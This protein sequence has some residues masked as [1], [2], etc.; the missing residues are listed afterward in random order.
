MPSVI[1]GTSYLAWGS[2]PDKTV[3]YDLD[4]VILEYPSLSPSNRYQLFITYY[5]VDDTSGIGGNHQSLTDGSGVEIHPSV[6]IPSAS[7]EVYS[8][9]VPASS[10]GDGDLSLHFRRDNGYRAVV[11][12][13]LLVE[14]DDITDTD[15]PSSSVTSPTSGS[16]IN[17]TTGV[18][19]G[20]ASDAGSGVSYVEV[21]IGSGNATTWY[22]VTSLTETG[23]WSFRWSLP[24][25]GTFTVRSRARDLAGNMETPGSGITVTVLNSAPAPVSMLS[26]HDTEGDSG[27][28]ISLSWNL[29]ADDGSGRNTVV[30][31][32]IL[33][34]ETGGDDFAEV[35]SV[36]AGTAEFV[37]NTAVDGVSYYYILRTVDSAGNYSDTDIY[38]PVISINNDIPDSD[39]PEDISSLSGV[40][41]NGF[42]YLTWVR[43]A[44]TAHDLV[45]QLIEVSS[46][47]SNWDSPVSLGKE[48]SSYKVTGLT[49][50]SPY[51]F[52]IRCLDSSGNLSPG[53]VAGPFTPDATAVITVSGT[54]SSDT[55]WAGGVYYVSGNLTVNTGVTLT[56]EPGV[57]VKFAPHVYMN[58]RGCLKASGTSD[59]PVVFTA[60]SD[61]TY[62]GDSNGDGPSEGTPG[63]WRNLYFYSASPESRLEHC[64]IKYAGYSNY[65]AI[66]LYYGSS[67]TVSDTEITDCSTHGLYTY[68]SD[69]VIEGCRISGNG[70]SG[71]YLR[72]SSPSIQGNELNNNGQHGIYCENTRAVISNNIITGNASYG[73]YFG[74]VSD[75][76]EIKD[77]TITGN[78]QSVR[79]PFSA[80]PGS[81]SGNVLTPNTIDQIEFYGNT[82]NRSLTLPA[83]PVYYQVSGT[84]TV[85]TGALLTLEPGI[86]WKFG[87]YAALDVSGAL[88]AAGTDSDRIIF[89]SWR[90]DSH[91]GDTNDDGPTSGEP[92]DWNGIRFYD[93]VID[94]L[95]M[96]DNCVVRYSGV[97]LNSVAI[98][99]NST[100]ITGGSGHGI[101]ISGS[102][103][104]QITNCTVSGHVQDGIYLH[105]NVQGSPV[106]RNNTIT[107]NTNGIY[108]D[109]NNNIAPVIDGN[110]ITANREWGIYFTSSPAAPVITGNTITGNLRPAMLP[111]TAVPGSSDGN[112]L[113]PNGIN[114]LGIRGNAR[115]DDFGLEVLGSG[116]EELNTYWILGTITA[117]G[118][119]SVDPGVVLKFDS[120]A[121]INVNGSLSALGTADRP[122]VFTS[123]RD[124]MYGG[125]TN[126]DGY[127]TV[128]LSGDWG[129]IAF[130]SS[131]DASNCVLSHAV[132][133]YGGSWNSGMI[134]V[135]NTTISVSDSIISNSS[136]NGLRTWGGDGTTLGGVTVF[137]NRD[138]GLHFQYGTATVEG[139]RIF[140]NRGDGIEVYSATLNVTGSEFFANNG[141]GIRSNG[142][143]TATDNYWGASDG[144]S[145]SG[146]G[147]GDEVTDGVTFEPFRTDGT[148]YSYF[149]AGG[150]GH[151][152]YGIGTPAVSGTPSVEWGTDAP[153]S[154]LYSL[155]NELTA[156]YIGLSPSASYRILVTYIEKD[157]GGSSQGILDG[158]GNELQP[159][160]VLPSSTPQTWDFTI[161]SGSIGEGGDLKLRLYRTAGLRTVVSELLLVKEDNIDN[162]PP[163]ISLNQPAS[164]AVIPCC[165]VIVSGTVSDSGILPMVEVGVQSEDGNISWY[166]ATSVDLSGSW[167][168][169]WMPGASGMFNLYAR[170]VDMAGNR[171]VTGPV[172]VK[173]DANAPAPA[174]GLVVQAV[175]G[176]SNTLKLFWNRSADDG[177]GADD[178]ARYEIYRSQD[179]FGTFTLVGMLAAGA[180]SYTDSTV[181][182]GVNYFYYVKTV[183]SAGK[184]SV[185]DICGPAHSPGEAD[186]NPPEDVT[187]LE[188]SVTQLGGSDISVLLRWQPSMDSEGDL[189]D[190]YLY[191]S[192]D[193][194]HFG[195]NA[196]DYDNGE[197]LSLGRSTT[198]KQIA[199]L[200]AGTIYSFKITVVDEVP[201][202][203]PGVEISVTPS[204]SEQEVVS[205]SGSLD[206][207]LSLAPGVY[208][209]NSDL[210]V[211]SGITL[212]FAPGSI[213]KFAQGRGMTVY[214]TLVAAG[215]DGNPVV[216]TS[217]TDDEWGGDTNGDGPSV[218]TPGYWK[219][220]YFENSDSSV[221][222]DSVIRFGGSSGY[223]VYLNRSNI[224][225]EDCLAEHS[226]SS[227]ILTYNSDT[228]I[229]GCTIRDN[230]SNGLNIQ[231]GSPLITGNLITGNENGIYSR[232]AT[233]VIDDN[234]ITANN[235][236]G[237]YHYDTRNAPVMS[238]NTITGNN[239]CLRIPASA[240]PDNTN[241]L[242]PNTMKYME[243][244]GNSLSSDTDVPV[245][246]EGTADEMRTYV[247]S[248]IIT[249][250]LYTF[251]NVRPGVIFK[252]GPSAGLS[253]QGVILASGS[254]D[255]HIV[256]TSLKDDS[257]GGDTNGDGS[258]TMPAP[259]DWRNVLISGAFLDN[260]SSLQRVDILYA[261]LS[262]NPALNFD[263]T[264]ANVSDC[265]VALSGS[266]GIRIYDS[267]VDVTG[268]RIWGNRGDGIRVEYRS[269][270]VLSFNF[271]STNQAAGIG[272][273]GF[274]E[275]DI[276]NNRFLLNREFGV[277]NT[278]GT[279]VDAAACWWG[280]VDGSGPH[281]DTDNPTGT[282]DAVGGSI[283]FDPY[284][285]ESP[286]DFAYRNFSE[287]A[288][289]AVGTMSEP[290]LAQGELYDG[291]DS[292]TLRPDRT[293]AWD[294]NRVTVSFS[295]L[296]TSK[297][298]RIR[299]SYF[300]GDPGTTIQSLEDGYGNVIHEPLTMPS[301]VPIQYEFPVP[302]ASYA[303]GSLELNFIHENP[304]SSIR[305]AVPEVLLIEEVAELTPPRLQD[306]EFNDVDGSGSI[307]VGDEYYFH[308]SEE[309]DRSAMSDNSTDANIHLAP[310]SAIYGTLNRIRWSGDGSTVIVTVTDGFTITGTEAVTPT[311]LADLYGNGAIGTQ[312]LVTEDTVA[313][314]LLSLEWLDNDNSVVLSQGDQF[315]FVFSEAMNTSVIRDMT[316]D[317]N[318]HLRPEG[319]MRYG[320]VNHI[321]WS[322]DGR[323]LTVT[324]TEGYTILG[325]ELVT[326][327]SFVTD[328]AGNRVI[329]SIRLTG[330]DSVAPRITSVAFDDCDGSGD[331]SAG[332]RY[333]FT[334]SEEMRISSLSDNTVEANENLSPG[335]RLYGEINRISWNEAKNVCAVTI[336]QGFTITGGETVTPSS[337]LTDIAG[338]PVANTVVLPVTDTVA[339]E[340]VSVQP[341]YFSP[342][343]EVDDY[344][345][346]IRFNSS[347]DTGIEPVIQMAGTGTVQPSVTGSGTWITT[348][349]AND[350]YITPAIALHS[351]M[352]GNITVAVSEASDPAGNVMDVTPAVYSF[353]LDATP[354]EM[355]EAA[356]I[357]QGC[358]SAV[359]SWSGYVAPPDLAAFAIYRED[360]PF[361]SLE[362]LSPFAW[363]DKTGDSYEFTALG[364]EHSYYYAVA[365]VD[366]TGNHVNAVNPG[367]IRLPRPVPPPVNIT[368]MPGSDPDMA[369]ISWPS[370]DTSELCGLS[371][372]RLYYQ[373]DDFSSVEGMTPV[374]VLAPDEFQAV[375]KGLDRNRTYHF[376]VAAFNDADGMNPA[377]TTTTWSD[378]YQGD[379]DLDLVLGG[380]ESH[381]VEIYNTMRIISGGRITIVPGTTLFFAPG[382]GI[383]V[384]GGTLTVS[385]TALDPVIMT[386]VN[387]RDGGHPMPGDWDGVRLLQ[388]S[389]AS[390]LEHLFIKYGSGLVVDNSRPHVQ[391]L[392][393]LNNQGAGLHVVNDARLS[394]TAL[395]AA[396][397][398]TGLLLEDTSRLDVNQ[399]VI[400]FN[401]MNA[402]ATGLYSLDATDNWWGDTDNATVASG[403]SGKVDF[404]PFMGSEPLLTPAI[405]IEGNKTLTGSRDIV[406][407]TAC[408]TA[409]EMRISEDSTFSDAYF[410]SFAPS[411]PFTLSAGGGE[412]TVFAQY[413]SATGDISDPVSITINYVTEGPVIQTF[414]LNEGEEINRPV[415]VTASVTS[416][417]PFSTLRFLVDDLLV[418]ETARTSLECRWDVTTLENRIYRAR[419]VATDK[420]GNFAVTE[421][422]ILVNVEPPPA[423]VITY[424]STDISVSSGPVSIRG[425]AEPFV[426]VRLVRN[427]FVQASVVAS[428]DGSFEFQEVTLD[429]GVNRFV[430]Q[431]VDHVGISPSSNAIEV[432]LDSGPPS[433]VNLDDPEIVS[434]QG[435][436]L[437]WSY[438]AEGERPVRFNVYRSLSMFDDISR[439]VLVAEDI[440]DLSFIDSTAPDGTLYYAITGF[441]SAGNMS[442]LSNVESVDFDNTKPV[443]S[444]SY[445]KT[446]PFGVED[447]EI[448]L[449]ASEPLADLP[450][451]TITPE[452]SAYTH[453]IALTQ[454][455]ETTYRGSYSI[456]ATFPPGTARLRV[457]GTDLAGNTFS[458]I[459]QGTSF[460][461]DNRPPEAVLTID[462]EPPVQVLEER[463]V[464]IAL[465]LDEP[466]AAGTMPILQ[467]SPP[468]GPDITV[469]LSGEGTSW[470][471]ALVLEPSMGSGI[472]RF[473]LQ[474]EDEIGNHGGSFS[475]GE[476]LEIYNSEY[477]TPPSAPVS[478]HANTGKAGAVHVSWSSVELADSYNIYRS[479]GNCD[480]TP[481]T[482]VAQDLTA[483]SFEDTPPADGIYCYAVTA[484]RRGAESAL[485]GRVAMLSDRTPPEQ[486]ENLTVEPGDSGISIMWQGP[487][488]G[489]APARYAVYRNGDLIRTV[490]GATYSITDNPSVGG[491]YNYVVASS[492]SYGNENASAPVTFDL[493]VG[494]V[495]DLV[496]SVMQGGV[497]VLSWHSSDPGVTGYNVYRGDRK[498]ND[499]PLANPTYTDEFYTASGVVEY[500][501]TAVNASGD[502]SPA[503]VARVFPVRLGVVANPDEN[504][505]TGALVTGFI[506][507]YR[508]TVE[509]SDPAN[510]LMI[511][512]IGYE[513]TVGK[514]IIYT[515][516]QVVDQEIEASGSLEVIRNIPCGDSLAEHLLSITL[517]DVT[518]T[519]VETVYRADFVFGDVVPSAPSV[520]LSMGSIPVAGGYANVQTCFTN[521]GYADIA[522]LAS[523][524]NGNE[525]G[526]ISVAVEN[527]DGLE[528][529]RGWYHGI[530]QGA[531]TLPDGTVWM[532][533]ASGESFCVDVPVLVPENLEE[534]T[535]LRFV[536]GIDRMFARWGA[537]VEQ[538]SPGL[539]GVITSRITQT[540]Y[541]AVAR[542]QQDFYADNDV[543]VISGQAINR[544]TGDPEPDVPLKIGFSVRGFQWYVDV[545]SDANG[546]FSYDYTPPPGL[547]GHFTVW[548]AH[549]DVFDI[550]RQD[551]FDVF[552][553]YCKPGALDIRMSKGDSLAFSIDL[554]NPGDR[555]LTGLSLVVHGYTVDED[556][557]RTEEPSFGGRADFED[558]SLVIEPGGHATL[559]MAVNAT[560]D[561]P[562]NGLVDFVIHTAEGATAVLP[563]TLTLL[564]AIP[565][566]NVTEPAAGYVDISVDRGDVQTHTITVTNNGLR[567]LQDV[568]LVPPSELSWVQTNLTPDDA[569]RI[570]LGDIPVGA[571][572][573][574][575]VVFAPPEDVEAGYH[576]D[577]IILKGSNY[578]Q[579]FRINLYAMVTSSKVGSVLLT[580]KDMFGQ[581]VEGATVRLQNNAI[582]E[583]LAPV[584]TDFN[585]EAL[586][587]DV[588]EGEWIWQVIAD[589]CAPVG[590]MV[591]VVPGQVVEVEAVVLR[592]LV[593]VEF[594]VEPVPFTDRY[595]IKL[596]QTFETHVPAP[597]L[598]LDPPSFTFEDVSDA[599]Q[600][601]LI[602][603]AKNFGLIKIHDVT[604][605]SAET[606]WGSL[607]PLIEYIPELAAMQEVEIPYKFVFRGDAAPEAKGLDSKFDAGGWV[608]CT[609]GGFGGMFDA[610]RTL[611][612]V[613]GGYSSCYGH[614]LL[615]IADALLVFIH[616]WNMPTDIFGVVVNA[617]SCAAQQLLSAS[618]GGGGTAA[619]PASGPAYGVPSDF[620]CFASGTPILMADGTIK[621]IE[622]VKAGDLV[623]GFSGD[624]ARV[625]QTYHRTS[626]QIRE[627]RYRNSV[628]ELRRLVTTD[629]H[630][631][632]T[633]NGKWK[634][635]R[636]LDSDDVLTGPDRSPWQIVSNVR[637]NRAMEVYNLDVEKYRSYFANGVLV[638]E[639]CGNLEDDPVTAAF[640]EPAKEG[641]K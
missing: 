244:L 155:D 16:I 506:D 531:V 405:G 138:D 270:A 55:V 474:A 98:T 444:V 426:T 353:S 393:V 366:T 466:L 217:F 634:A 333:L 360:G 133:R 58:I 239:I 186:E 248:G 443:F 23:A 331:V 540:P 636:K 112:T 221:V 465:E 404:E 287:S 17:G 565:V 252:F 377:V 132:I 222:S 56:I 96:L 449:A 104:P 208:Y 584:K 235:S 284:V 249:V 299:V 45:D 628:G 453:V 83:G 261:G 626:D 2:E 159:V 425:N 640:P 9:M 25:D 499:T 400:K 441:D 503:R 437:S 300:T 111:L 593:S 126:N 586:L 205:L 7:P 596:E 242:T 580:V 462:Q 428:S 82:L 240:F 168:Y 541:Y 298:Y 308:F 359:I 578:E 495:N 179:R 44:D 241:T 157:Q 334:F 492:D 446:P 144:P 470:S 14:R 148:E 263:S 75:S 76:P 150:T 288:G 283:N 139:S 491:V 427:G 362:E 403:V 343:G 197:P 145:G 556:G 409:E 515:D 266:H 192:V 18:I 178:V 447:V 335:G 66:D 93:T 526:D 258:D 604:I 542:A 172:P 609:L 229:S 268:S 12:Q 415:T 121:G 322:D 127:S 321:H 627:I 514:D 344:M 189:I 431:A 100:E 232:Y 372:F 184:S 385:G 254:R 345:L 188:A 338:N 22:P 527:G 122:V 267:S 105:Y 87:E 348:F 228:V 521:N 493:T 562:D 213:V 21:G 110:T 364:L 193:G 313:P 90:D 516:T 555:E 342:V 460:E 117:N 119:M 554:Y 130:R 564:P 84:A 354:P 200:V 212:T 323:T 309:M 481:D 637:I 277:N 158:D 560:V 43:S 73:I 141:Y 457:S 544:Q 509:N 582:R 32:S 337:L 519:G 8:W 477:P 238:G 129:G 177:Q 243:L 569:G 508:L 218:G 94:F 397:N 576:Q 71:L 320:S 568:E 438:S 504:G 378:P 163:S 147:S 187:G 297:R 317:A 91:G 430:C 396:Y 595:E 550:L 116:S 203:S 483:V 384:E 380:G 599:F 612:S 411:I 174:T 142:S 134:Y 494:M 623:M 471:G 279:A 30:S 211:P 594:T 489:E 162:V 496:A 566:I 381:E 307:S 572:R 630:L 106:F 282:G 511:H 161:G 518:D 153:F 183:D 520:S 24:V 5:N 49:N 27:G 538:A 209:I 125:D 250:P 59:L 575:D 375:V 260:N 351:G 473:I 328:V 601:S 180:N 302:T 632:W 505:D 230:A 421:H 389:D 281:S 327:S 551:E 156:D 271:I 469:S 537:A 170:A 432:A 414:S 603:K 399:S 365:A 53:V 92:G 227:A 207:D 382:S 418:C 81:D 367:E 408:R 501:V 524:G 529:G 264:E 416:A 340:I 539:E 532:S 590:D 461:V 468:S 234:N 245:W 433:A 442:P 136:S 275:L 464:S 567:D 638:H 597:V 392:S 50:G 571:S 123:I 118:A 455:T 99:L 103:S 128:P 85:A 4:Q 440:R 296:D 536:A 570:M 272:I 475:Q 528:L 369:I 160:S 573:S 373:E 318:V 280:D 190:Q 613:F 615:P 120:G 290:V 231:S 401:G 97:S 498:I 485:S 77:N 339:P 135:E 78:H 618:P 286:I 502:E 165:P 588:Q 108:F 95:T 332:D 620:Q 625:K 273:Y 312:V 294:E 316:Q 257:V 548:A 500:R 610:I 398:D 196:P 424:P 152:G 28:S 600:T 622:Q 517:H 237:V 57:I 355:P 458:G 361:D 206:N 591:T 253:V 480:T 26:A 149:N 13:V 479:E 182:D 525:P 607:V 224:D 292:A 454:E 535:E 574:F 102:G 370:Y 34:S 70:G 621:P 63:Y 65:S 589:G 303:D 68:S 530:P 214:G 6:A 62:G 124:D 419:I 220:I 15:P 402:Q 109:G 38:G 194:V 154:I 341:N 467:F 54:I 1:Q 641:R 51:W 274:S 255:S 3:L 113:V 131:A 314:R 31:Y 225:V 330:R 29:S 368:V 289:T 478:V 11:S 324:V 376:A 48:V 301:S 69:P 10:T 434:G 356:L 181:T 233:P 417:N 251:M 513:M 326:P 20:T 140:G 46:D 410:V 114:V 587:Q 585:G 420:A 547:S 488:V 61:D 448:V 265:L 487:S 36:S 510:V 101:Y 259:G 278:T 545:S 262:G 169:R 285:T 305:A 346:T 215:T 210:T 173:V 350:T 445:D 236:Y 395:L 583:E 41:G 559:N 269:Q 598:V 247:V 619:G 64:I 223:M 543:I 439:A 512:E 306:I 352:D 577:F 37:D 379:I 143:V 311:D 549:P 19:S 86:I 191:V 482:L 80:L 592:S 459:P 579:E 39:A 310:G 115:G 546:E 602:V 639:R 394:T 561:A 349:F 202:E 256:F 40:P 616:V 407:R 387:D 89:T 42:V 435:I 67:I 497:P 490:S 388:G 484:L 246:A 195:S 472:G 606:E 171:T 608:D 406:L 553:L 450:V 391:A 304:D 605:K 107:G 476:Y 146:S 204:G 422:N 635:A 534:G 319:G 383:E 47:G 151:Y 371:G 624:A 199:G 325:D 614:D 291:W 219:G 347:M 452:G 552:R 581:P 176:V 357:Y 436:R 631:F 293:V 557:N 563:A 633:T 358:D 507:T 412:K 463:T 201:N 363:V 167:S 185:S 164:N 72:S 451:L 295:G 617:I 33:R 60:W 315:V 52:R 336:T 629:G 137:G 522:F 558:G 35:G 216:F 198:S 390:S 74:N 429:E 611:H 166:P 226:S 88:H 386:S 456:T 486:P 523:R 329:G 423:P 79:L 533:L 276:N 413:R 374:Q 175:P